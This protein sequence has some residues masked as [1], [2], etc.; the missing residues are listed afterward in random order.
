[1]SLFGLDGKGL[2]PRKVDE[3]KKNISDN[4]FIEK[5]YS[6]EE[7]NMSTAQSKTVGMYIV[8]DTR[9]VDDSDAKRWFIE[10]IKTYTKKYSA[11]RK[12]LDWE[13]I[14]YSDANKK[15]FIEQNGNGL[16]SW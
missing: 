1:M 10:S 5:E 6:K 8:D 4:S 11:P 15:Y 14:L 2:D 3:Y 9:I 12:I 16:Y 13:D 7:N